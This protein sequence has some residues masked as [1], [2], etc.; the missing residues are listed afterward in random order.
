MEKNQPCPVVKSIAETGGTGGTARCYTMLL[1]CLHRKSYKHQHIN[2]SPFTI[3]QDDIETNHWNL[4]SWRSWLS[5]STLFIIVHHLDPH[6]SWETFVFQWLNP[7]LF[8]R[9][10][11][12]TNHHWDFAWNKSSCYWGYLMTMETVHVL[13]T[14]QIL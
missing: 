8:L 13:R 1:H 11:C 3:R 4:L 2:H 14:F 6:F 12:T 9:M 7:Y 10:G 5:S